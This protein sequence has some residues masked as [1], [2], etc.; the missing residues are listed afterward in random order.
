MLFVLKFHMG[1]EF[2]IMIL[3]YTMLSKVIDRSGC[4]R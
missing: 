4:K 2:M 1:V 3:S